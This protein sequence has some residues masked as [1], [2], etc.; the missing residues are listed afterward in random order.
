MIIPDPHWFSPLQNYLSTNPDGAK[1]R[2][3]NGL[4]LSGDVRGHALHVDETANEA[5]VCHYYP[6][7]EHQ[8]FFL[9]K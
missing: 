8:H 5:D 6:L 9:T 7:L 3:E 4:A 2:D 1:E